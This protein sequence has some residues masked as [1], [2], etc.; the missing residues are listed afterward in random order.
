MTVLPVD[1]AEFR[2]RLAEIDTRIRSAAAGEGDH[3]VARP[4]GGDSNAG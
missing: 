3:R 2:I 4:D 1:D